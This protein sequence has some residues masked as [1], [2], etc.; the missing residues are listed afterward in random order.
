MTAD[1]DVVHPQIS[2][3]VAEAITT[4]GMIGRMADED[5]GKS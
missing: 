4:T 2:E 3:P 1:T 5:H